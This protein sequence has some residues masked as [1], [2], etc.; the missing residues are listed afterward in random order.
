MKKANPGNG[1]AYSKLLYG[2]KNDCNLADLAQT[3]K[4][5]STCSRECRRTTLTI[6]G[7]DGRNMAMATKSLKGDSNTSQKVFEEIQSKYCR[8]CQAEFKKAYWKEMEG[9]N[10]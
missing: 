5:N 10:E 8:L 7:R 6:A 9:A 2:D 4:N 1:L 3:N